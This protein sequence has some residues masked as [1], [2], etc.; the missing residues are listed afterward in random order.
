MNKPKI[1]PGFA[2][3]D[4][5]D[6]RELL[7]WQSRY[8][9]EEGKRG[10][11]FEAVYLAAL[12]TAVPIAIVVLWL[13]YPK[14]WLK[15]SDQKYEPIL[16]YALAWLSGL[17]GGTLFDVKWLYHSVARQA[18]HL[19]RRLWRLFTPHISGGL[20]FAVVALISSG[21]LRVFDRHSTGSLS[22]IIGVGFLAGY[23]SDSAA[24]KLAEIAESLFG[25]GR[26]KERHVD[27]FRQ[28]ESDKV[29]STRGTPTQSTPPK[30]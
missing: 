4:P 7:D 22:L 8:T 15:L 13:D 24:A 27:R 18:W 2:P 16:R 12:M 6:G 28:E 5:T 1:V 23:F 25:A 19:D 20:A 30:P 17:L 26:G 9:E 10:I 14:N 3:S 11:R 21:L 29:E